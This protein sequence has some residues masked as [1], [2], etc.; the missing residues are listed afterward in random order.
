MDPPLYEHRKL[1]LLIACALT[2]SLVTFCSGTKFENGNQRFPFSLIYEHRKLVLLNALASNFLLVLSIP[3]TKFENENQRFSFSLIY[4]HRKQNRF[5]SRA[6]K[7]FMRLRPRCISIGQLKGRYP[8]TLP[9]YLSGSLPD[10]LLVYSM[11]YLILRS[12]SRLDAF[13]GYPI[14]TWLPGLY[15]WRNNRY[16]SGSSIP[17]LSY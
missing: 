13:S 1:V 2:C 10:T 3:I 6:N 4:E 17:V 8:L 16:T 11:R 12:A 9:T 5:P 15:S 7:G 14:R